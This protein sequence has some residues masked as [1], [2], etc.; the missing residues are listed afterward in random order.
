MTLNKTPTTL[1][2]LHLNETNFVHY[3]DPSKAK[4]VILDYLRNPEELSDDTHSHA[5]A[6]LRNHTS[7]DDLDFALDG[8]FSGHSRV[9]IGGGSQHYVHDEDA[10]GSWANVVRASEE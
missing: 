1:E 8:I 6:A 2:T 7:A 4:R 10:N 5:L 9:R 3:A